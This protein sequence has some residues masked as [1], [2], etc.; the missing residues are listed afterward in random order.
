MNT[1]HTRGSRISPHEIGRTIR[2]KTANVTVGNSNYAVMRSVSRR[3]ARNPAASRTSTL[4]AY[5][6]G[7]AVGVPSTA[8]VTSRGIPRGARAGKGQPERADAHAG[9]RPGG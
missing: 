3:V 1:R 2:K 6:P 9:A 8:P 7:L 4:N 5:R